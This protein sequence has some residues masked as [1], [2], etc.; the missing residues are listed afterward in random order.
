MAFSSPSTR[1]IVVLSYVSITQTLLPREE[2]VNS[3][4]L[5]TWAEAEVQMNIADNAVRR[6]KNFFIILDVEM[7]YNRT[8]LKLSQ[9]MARNKYSSKLLF[10]LF[11][12][13]TISGCR[14]EAQPVDS[15]FHGMWRLYKIETIDKLSG[16]WVYDT[17]FTGWNGYILY[18]GLGH[19]GAQITPKGYKDFDAN[20]NMERLTLEGGKE[21][22][23]FYQSNFVYFANYKISNGVIEHERLSATNPKDWGSVL[24]RDFEFRDDTILLTPHEILWGKK[25]RLWWVKL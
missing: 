9:M 1:Y 25:A 19:M 6:N 18:D 12:L 21:L 16:N 22:A 3:S 2:I 7:A 13:L 23:K 14:N 10:G 17:A 4:F 24:T 11:V 8:N 20:K 5:K 15:K